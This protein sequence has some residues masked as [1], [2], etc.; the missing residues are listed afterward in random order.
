MPK[1]FVHHMNVTRISNWGRSS[2]WRHLQTQTGT[3]R[4]S[5]PPSKRHR[6]VLLLYRTSGK[7]PPSLWTPSAPSRPPY[8]CPTP[9]LLQCRPTKGTG[10]SLASNGNVVIIAD[11]PSRSL[12]SSCGGWYTGGLRVVV[13]GHVSVIFQFCLAPFCP[14]GGV[15]FDLFA[16]VE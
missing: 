8:S 2:S 15:F 10:R 9:R 5:P 1:A 11:V 4:T 13:P 12:S 16:F 3:L 7:C 14:S 6:T